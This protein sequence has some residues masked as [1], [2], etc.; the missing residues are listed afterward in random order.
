MV[1]NG[2]DFALQ[3]QKP[4][5][6][7]SGETLGASVEGV[8]L[9]MPL[10]ADD[11]NVIL[12]GLGE[13][14][15]L[16]F[17]AQSLDV[18][19]LKAFA[20]RFG[21]L[22]VN[23]AGSFQETGHPE[24]M[25]LSNMVQDGQPVGFSDAGQDWHTDMSY[26]KVIAM[27]NVLHAI[28]VPRDNGRALG[29]TQF[30]NMHAAYDGLPQDLKIRLDGVTAV[31]DFE[32]FWEK[33]RNSGAG[34]RPP[35]SDEQK[36]RKPPVSHPIF[37]THP[38]TGRRVLYANPGYTVRINGV[39]SRESDELLAFLF[40]HQLQPDYIYEHRWTEGDLVVWDD[41]GTLH[42]AVADYGPHQHRLMRR[43]QAMADRVFTPPL[44]S[45]LPGS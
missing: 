14:G 43:C 38:I 16:R 18:K 31:H 44:S 19:A 13:Y 40:E 8:D 39:P 45:D 34:T 41:I 21:T 22:E 26:S 29:A 20:G 2:S 24:V 35:L 7:P 6:V 11:F 12:R 42:K 32:K 33:M 4:G 5:I 28:E 1:M 25:I 15:V 30:A 10:A 27:A 37:L 3:R 17:P 9:S 36:R 23:V